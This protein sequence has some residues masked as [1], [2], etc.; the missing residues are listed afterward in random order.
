MKLVHWLVFVLGIVFLIV[1]FV[2]M[3]PEGFQL[4]NSYDRNAYMQESK[5]KYNTLSQISDVKN[6][7]SFQ[8]NN[9]D[10]I[11]K[12]NSEILAAL[13]TSDIQASNTSQS[14]QG[15]KPAFSQATLPPPSKLYEETK[16]CEAFLTRDSCAKLDDP[17]FSNC[18]VCIKGGTPF[19]FDNPNKHIGGLLLLPDD[20]HTAEKMVEGTSKQ[21]TY[22]PTI[23]DCPTGYFFATRSECEK[24]VN[25]LDCSEAGSSGGFSGGTTIEGKQ[26]V[27]QK[28]AQVVNANNL[29]IYDPKTRV[30]T[31]NLRVLTPAGTGKCQVLV[32]D[33]NKKQV[34]QGSSSIPGVE[35]IV[36]ILNVKE[37]DGLTVSVSLEAPY[38]Y[39][40]NQELYQIQLANK[41]TSATEAA[42]VCERYGSMQATMADLTNAESQSINGAE[43]CAPGWTSNGGLAFI[44]QGACGSRGVQQSPAKEGN[45]WC[46]GLRPP[47][48]VN[49]TENVT[50]ANWNSGQASAFGAENTIPYKR[51]V[52]LQWEMASG[53]SSRKVGFE[54]TITSVEGI[55]PSQVVSGK[56]IFSNLRTFGNFTASSIVRNP[57]YTPDAKITGDRLW[58]WTN[59]DLN[60]QV[61]FTAVVPGIFMDSYYPEDFEV[62]AYGP[63]VGSQESARMLQASPC[64]KAGQ[65]PG[66]YGLACLQTVFVEAGGDLHK[67]ELATTVG[68]V[69]LNAKGS[70]D[71]IETHL[72]YLYS[73]ATSGFDLDGNFVGKDADDTRDQINAASM[74]MFGFNI[75]TKCETI[76]QD[77]TGKVM[78]S[79][80]KGK[81]IDAFCLDFLW[82]NTGSDM[83][84]GV[85]DSNK[86]IQHTYTSIGQRFSGLRSTEGTK[87]SRINSPFT[88]CNRSGFGAP[89]QSNGQ[90]NGA[91]VKQAQSIGT[92]QQIQTFYN[93]LYNAANNPNSGTAQSDAVNMCYGIKKIDYSKQMK[94]L[95]GL[96]GWY[97]GNDPQNNASKSMDGTNISTWVDKSTNKNDMIAVIPAYFKNKAL[98][99][100]GNLVFSGSWYRSAKPSSYPIDVFIAVKLDSLTKP[101]DIVGLSQA[102]SDNSNSLT[103]GEYLPKV[104][105]NGSTIFQRTPG[106]TASMP[107]TANEYILMQ[108]S[109]AD[110]YFYINKNGK[111]IVLSGLY[112]WNPG[113]PYFQIGEGSMK[114][115]GKNLHGTVAEVL[116]F[117]RQLPTNERQI[118]QDYFQNKWLIAN[119]I[120]AYDLGKPMP[121]PPQPSLP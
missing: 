114:T 85:G 36:P 50:I 68:L 43:V 82:M 74:L 29:F 115:S 51:A 54:T 83:E 96:V 86:L 62:S 64:K 13:Q 109:I 90:I 67:G 38:R 2:G 87:R 111:N 97:D 14:L 18:G 71:A 6:P 37:R 56:N 89:I 55:G 73:V 95:Q 72:D 53:Q 69:S 81:D 102:T 15:I 58:I 26:V 107:E 63:L 108:W 52:L 23:G 16:K 46:M 20:K 5:Q 104:W 9:P 117:N 22:V 59:L 24:Q 48:S 78:I 65:T 94:G 44:S 93:S 25:R 17:N 119:M 39:G 61:V 100:Q 57:K 35:F 30:S 121:I 32:Y 91:N 11:K 12:K 8:S 45:V 7:S 34:G 60:Q 3:R 99:G 116:V 19:S 28:C 33:A 101:M 10:V 84:N 49:M 66:A 113:T 31:V 75:A 4:Y 79:P 88:L 1:Y 98:N 92:I 40:K 105:H 76:Q 47:Q 80:K 77:I 103:F 118:V 21:P 27:D 70:L 112:D 110:N 41:V 120:P 106:T 42:S